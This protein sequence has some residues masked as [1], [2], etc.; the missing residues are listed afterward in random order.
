MTNIKNTFD[1]PQNLDSET[2]KALGIKKTRPKLNI[3]DKILYIFYIGTKQNKHAL[4]LDQI[5]IA[6]YNLFHESEGKTRSKKEIAL[7]LY[8]M[9]GAPKRDGTPTTKTV[10]I[11]LAPGKRGAYKLKSSVENLAKRRIDD[12]EIPFSELDLKI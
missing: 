9:R 11:E 12:G 6:Y 2:Q 5:T 7:K 4:T 8:N 3:T 1:I 10:W